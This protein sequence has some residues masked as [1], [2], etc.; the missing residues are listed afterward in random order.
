[1]SAYSELFG[2]GVAAKFGKLAYPVG[3]SLDIIPIR[4]RRG[5][6]MSTRRKLPVLVTR[7]LALAVLIGAAIGPNSASAQ[8]II[9]NARWCM[10][11]SDLGGIMHCKFDSLEKCIFYARGVSNQCSLNPWYEGPPPRETKK[12]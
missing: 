12:K 3:Q 7:S 5:R 6:P 8:P 4:F 9:G 2:A 11:L 1:M 10:N